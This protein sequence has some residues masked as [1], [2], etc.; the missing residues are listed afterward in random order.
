M[1]S[2]RG[3]AKDPT[4]VKKLDDKETFDDVK[5]GIIKN[6]DLPTKVINEEL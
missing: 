3:R 1:S 2:L 4:Y 6:S 5:T